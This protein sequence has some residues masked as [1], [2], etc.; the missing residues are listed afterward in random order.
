MNVNQRVRGSGQ[1]ESKVTA[2]FWRDFG[3]TD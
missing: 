1:E 3:E 2:A